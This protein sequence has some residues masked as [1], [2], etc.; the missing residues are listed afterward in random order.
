MLDSS[1]SL[2][3]SYKLLC[4]PQTFPGRCDCAEKW[5]VLLD[6]L[7]WFF[8]L[9]RWFL[10]F[11]VFFGCFLGWTACFEFGFSGC[12]LTAIFRCFPTDLLGP[13]AEKCIVIWSSSKLTIDFLYSLQVVGWQKNHIRIFLYWVMWTDF[14]GFSGTPASVASYPD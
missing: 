9:F 7:Y 14:P 1:C 5:L 11:G 12:F 3:R 10:C 6:E 4:L 8:G 13:A 2:S